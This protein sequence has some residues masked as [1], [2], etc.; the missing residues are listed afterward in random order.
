MRPISLKIDPETLEWLERWASRERLPRSG[1]IREAIRYYL[2]EMEKKYGRIP[3]RVKS[4][5]IHNVNRSDN[6]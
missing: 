3:Y 4:I 5:E 1:L 6:T 2:E